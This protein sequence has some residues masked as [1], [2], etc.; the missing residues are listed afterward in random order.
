MAYQD[1][2][3]D[4]W[5]LSEDKK[6]RKTIINLHC[7]WEKPYFV[8]DSDIRCETPTLAALVVS[9][10]R[11]NGAI[12]W[13]DSSGKSIYQAKGYKVIRRDILPKRIF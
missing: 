5:Y 3:Y 9:G 2:D 12:V 1:L 13:K 4:E 8:V 7:H 10:S 11:L 6:R